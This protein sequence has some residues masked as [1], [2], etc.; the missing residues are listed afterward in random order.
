MKIL[1]AVLAHDG[2]INTIEKTLDSV[3]DIE[4]VEIFCYDTEEK[5]IQKAKDRKIILN[6]LKR[7]DIDNE[8]L[9]SKEIIIGAGLSEDGVMYISFLRN[10]AIQKANDDNFDYL[11]FVD[12]DIII[13]KNAIEK[14]LEINSDISFGWYF[15]KR[16]PC[17]NLRLYGPI[18]IDEVMLS[19]EFI[20]VLHGGGSGMLINKRI[21]NNFRFDL[22]NG[23]NGESAP[24]CKKVIANGFKVMAN[25]KVYFE[26]IGKD[27]TDE[28]LN[29]ANKKIKQW[30]L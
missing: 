8:K 30:N 6:I 1:T 29:Y 18:T 10:T 27:Y 13:P 7:P 20:D 22:Y 25:P 26:H 28:G 17:V 2:R 14:L 9:L 3:S 11:F 4:N 24:F 19:G 12:S 5:C 23:H 15:N 21:I 16:L